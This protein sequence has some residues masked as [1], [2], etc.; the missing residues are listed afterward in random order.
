[1]RHALFGLFILFIFPLGCDLGSGEP[2]GDNVGECDGNVV[3]NT[4]CEES[5]WDEALD[6]DT[7]AVAATCRVDDDGSAARCLATADVPAPPANAALVWA[8]PAAVVAAETARV[9]F[10]GGEAVTVP[11]DAQITGARS[12]DL[13]SAQMKLTWTADG[14]AYQLDFEFTAADG[15]W[16]TA[17]AWVTRDQDAD[18]LDATRLEGALGEWWADDAD[19]SHTADSHLVLTGAQIRALQ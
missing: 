1:M 16:R 15:R 3:R 19:L 18:S 9:V 12:D 10:R 7:L 17:H 6:C 4:I 2:I 13:G 8:T 11:A 5:C 14:A